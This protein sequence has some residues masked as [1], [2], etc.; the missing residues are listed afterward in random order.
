MK[1]KSDLER[2][3]K[4]KKEYLRLI[5]DLGYDYDGLEG[6]ESLKVLID[7]LVD[8]AAKGLRND[9]RSVIYDGGDGTRKKNILLE[10]VEE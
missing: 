9:D 5:Y 8:L 7:E 6:A 3:N 10:D 1:K 2:E 4:I